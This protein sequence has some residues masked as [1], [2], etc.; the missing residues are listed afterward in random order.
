MNLNL[1]TKVGLF[2]VVGLLLL[3]GLSTQVNNFRLFEKKGYTIYALVDDVNGLEI[4]AKVKASGL[5]IGR[6]ESFEIQGNKVK[7]KMTIDE[8]IKIPANSI[9]SLKQESLLGV[10]FLDIKLSNDMQLLSQND[11]LTKNQVFASFDQTSDSIN[12]AA[13][14]IKD[15]VN[16]LNKIVTKNEKNINELIKHF[17]QVGIEFEKT[18]KTINAKLPRLL[19]KFNKVEDS[20]ILAANNVGAMSKEFEQ[21]GKDINKKLPTILDKFEKIEDGVQGVINDNKQN[22]KSA[23]KNIDGAAVEVKDAFENIDVAAKNVGDAFDKLDSYLESTTKSQLEVSFRNEYMQNDNYNKIYFGLDY[24]PK[25]MIHYLLDIIST[26][27]YTDDG[28]GNPKTTQL[29]DKG[30]YVFSAQY[31][32]DF[33]NLRARIGIIENTGGLGVDYYNNKR[34][35]VTSLE[36][37]DMNAYN[38]VRGDNPHAKALFRYRFLKHLNLYLGYDNFLNSDAKS[39]SF[40]AGINFI[41]TDLKYLLG[42]SSGLAQ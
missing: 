13:I 20:F 28:T 42:S 31:G 15:F 7:V 10:K 32:K 26:D 16:N 18:G 8:N 2:V 30:R 36:V 21:T 38:D 23:I 12:E 19:D 1:E 14:S 22:L 24:S 33:D 39:V 3:F 35:F 11:T 40:G 5:N 9:V 17:K 37:F 4:N 25:P 6:V 27:D 41:D 34:D 29:H